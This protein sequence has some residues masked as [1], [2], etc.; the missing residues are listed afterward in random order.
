MVSDQ[1]EDEVHQLAS[2][3]DIV[4]VLIASCGQSGRRQ[5]PERR[6]TCPSHLLVTE[7]YVPHAQISVGSH[8]VHPPDLL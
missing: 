5:H 4:L 1:G 3:F 6:D 8:E 2:V 7:C